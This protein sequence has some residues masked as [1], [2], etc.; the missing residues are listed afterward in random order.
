[1]RAYSNISFNVSVLTT[2]ACC[3]NGSVSVCDLRLYVNGGSKWNNFTLNS[4]V[5]GN[6]LWNASATIGGVAEDTN[7]CVGIFPHND[8]DLMS[9]SLNVTVQGMLHLFCCA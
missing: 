9:Q 6:G 2:S 1:M 4:Q 3:C 5:C 7:F 8:S